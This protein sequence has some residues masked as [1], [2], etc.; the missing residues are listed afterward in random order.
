MEQVVLKQENLPEQLRLL[1]DSPPALGRPSISDFMIKEYGTDLLPGRILE[2]IRMRSGLEEITIA[3]CIEEE[4]LISYR[5]SLCA[6]DDDELHL[7]IIEE[8]YDTA[9]AGHQRGAMTLDRL[10]RMY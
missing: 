7:G 9:L 10:D 5:G 8:H 1:A 6:L 2:A 3:E 4:G